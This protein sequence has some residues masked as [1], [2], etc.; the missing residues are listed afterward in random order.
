[1]LFHTQMLHVD[2]QKAELHGILLTKICLMF[3]KTI[4]NGSLLFVNTEVFQF[5]FS[6]KW[7]KVWLHLDLCSK[8]YILTWK[9]IR[10][11]S[12]L[13]SDMWRLDGLIKVLS[14][15]SQYHNFSSIFASSIYDNF[16]FFCSV[17][18]SLLANCCWLC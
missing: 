13:N 7:E 4:L 5:F 3:L 10:R 14:G 11:L 16:L 12:F 2:E 17:G 15:K 1:M 18:F 8:K 6:L 9:S